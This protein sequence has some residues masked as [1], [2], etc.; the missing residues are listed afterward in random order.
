MK[1]IK[2]EHKKIVIALVFIIMWILCEAFVVP[3]LPFRHHSMTISV[4]WL[5]IILL[6]VTRQKPPKS[7]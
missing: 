7:D 4:L 2:Q 3:F 6:I 5:V 1:P